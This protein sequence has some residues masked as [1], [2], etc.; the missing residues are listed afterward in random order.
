MAKGKTKG[1][2][3]N[4]IEFKTKIINEYYEYNKSISLIS[5]EY[6]ISTATISRLIN[7]FNKDKKFDKLTY[8]KKMPIFNNPH[9]ETIY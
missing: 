8:I 6:E 1:S 5:K 9:D 4:D 3:D 7:V 2:K